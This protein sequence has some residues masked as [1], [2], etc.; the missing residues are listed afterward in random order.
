MRLTVT[1][2]SEA[3]E[4]YEDFRPLDN[5]RQSG[6]IYLGEIMLPKL[7][8]LDLFCFDGDSDYIEGFSD[9]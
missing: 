9:A 2:K 4:G 3:I 1:D 8:I 7:C 5:E 6:L